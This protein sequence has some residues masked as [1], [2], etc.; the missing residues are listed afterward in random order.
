MGRGLAQMV[1]GSVATCGSPVGAAHAVA[2]RA[3]RLVERRPV[4]GQAARYLVVGGGSTLLNGLIFLLL[5]NWWEAVPA[6]LV[7]LVLSTAVSTE[8]HRRVTFGGAEVR[9]L[10]AQVQNGGTV[11]FYAFYSSSVLLT[12]GVLVTDPS[13]LLEGAAVAAASVLGGTCRFLLLRHWVF[14]APAAVS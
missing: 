7:A 14:R 5:R 9:P 3:T 2:A 10:R 13:P 8:M 1:V 6:N 4:L 11:A 12:V